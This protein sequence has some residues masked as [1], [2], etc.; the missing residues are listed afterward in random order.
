MKQ[1][2]MR[3][4]RVNSELEKLRSETWQLWKPDLKTETGLKMFKVII[5]IHI[6]YIY[7]CTVSTVYTIYIHG[8]RS[9]VREM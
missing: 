3:V 9:G 5:V 8:L 4:A 2:V 6:H 1:L 7:I